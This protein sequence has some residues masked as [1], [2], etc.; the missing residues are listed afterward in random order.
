[1]AKFELLPDTPATPSPAARPAKFQLLPEEMS[2]EQAKEITSPSSRF[3]RGF[4]RS[5][6]GAVQTLLHAL[7]DNIVGRINAAA[8]KI[9][10]E[11]TLLG[12]L[13]IKSLTKKAVDD[14][15][16]QDQR[17]FDQAVGINDPGFDAAGMLGET[18]TPH[19][20]ALAGLGGKVALAKKGLVDLSTKLGA[21]GG[22]AASLQPV[23][24]G[25]DF[26][27]EKRDQI[28]LGGGTSAVLGPLLDK[29]AE[30][31]GRFISARAAAGK[32]VTSAEVAEVAK[33]SL[34]EDGVDFNTLPE[35]VK[36]E[37]LN[38][39]SKGSEV[40]RLVDPRHVLRKNDFDKF[41]I[42]P[43]LG[44]VTR[45]PAQFSQELNLRG[46]SGVGEP[47]TKRLS[48]QNQQ[49]S[50]IFQKRTQ[51]APGQFEAGQQLIDDIKGKDAGMLDKVRESYAKYRESTG[52]TLNVPA[53]GLAHDFAN[54]NREFAIPGV[55][56]S[57]F[58]EF[59]LLDGKQI[60]NLD[61]DE[62][63]KLI[64]VINN[65]YDPKNLAE[66][67][68]L[69]ALRDAVVKSM[70]EATQ[71]ISDGSLSAQLA[72]NARATATERFKMI[73]ENPAFHAAINKK[74][75]PDD[76][77]KKYIIGGKVGDIE[78]LF[79]LT[80]PET[81]EQMKI[82]F[83]RHLQNSA[84]GANAAGDGMFSQSKF[85]GELSRIGLK[86]LTAV[87][88]ERDASDMMALGRVMANIQ[89]RPA[90]SSVNESNTA[91]AVIN[92][93]SKR[94]TSLPYVKEFVAPIKNMKDQR[95][96]ENALS[97]NLPQG[98]KVIKEDPAVMRALSRLAGSSTVLNAASTNQ[99]PE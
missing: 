86:K 46:V 80:T 76:F 43:T 91:A 52:K 60:K 9:G 59:G 57:R 88:G 27:T 68:G 19:N 42:E 37:V 5:M 49:V 45:E 55:V 74:A 89:Q 7:P 44:Q 90:A 32:K 56:R 2:V 13:G 18:L 99:Q 1:M 69:D 83:M 66:K 85:N 23:T 78:N 14:R 82:Q 4:S 50:E 95:K 53:N 65:H 25:E 54:I 63:E 29:A 28:I 6:D 39:I 70:D 33:R 11:G 93:L 8:D 71:V 94:V 40:G 98:K 92:A 20:V 41:G 97:A 87:L 16:V 73:R 10:G 31:G 21:L 36:L 81:N 15:L 34:A 96:V 38:Q 30:F 67:R 24:S 12:N 61:I 17:S 77:I 62:A 3:T 22:A 47:I 72:K 35:S 51:G 48:D 79:K 26:A 84:Y 75:P 58:K 64:K